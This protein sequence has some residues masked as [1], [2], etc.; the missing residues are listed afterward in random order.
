MS[1]II[2]AVSKDV[3]FKP[4]FLNKLIKKLKNKKF[5]IS[6][7]V[8]VSSNKKNRHPSPW[9]KISY[10]QI[11]IIFFL[12]KIISLFSIPLKWKYKSTVKLVSEFNKIPYIYTDNLNYLLGNFKLNKNDIFISFQP[13]IIKNPQK[14]NFNLIN[15]HP[16]DLKLY[17]GIKPIFWAMIENQKILK[18]SVH[19]IDKGIDTGEIIKE[20]CLKIN[21]SLGDNYIAAYEKSPE[22]IL[23]AVEIIESCNKKNISLEKREKNDNGIYRKFPTHDDI[24][25]FYKIRKRTSFSFKNFLKLLKTF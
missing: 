6:C 23:D 16:G 4:F 3:I 21:N 11:G 13:Q 20:C 14:L 24:N 2:I 18:I 17:R 22:V 9:S 10:L 25:Y 5:Y 12:K 7:I 1:N 15:C 8:E 19:F